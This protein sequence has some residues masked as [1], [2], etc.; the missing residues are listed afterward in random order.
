MCAFICGG[1]LSRSAIVAT[2]LVCFS[3]LGHLASAQGIAPTGIAGRQLDSTATVVASVPAPP[4]RAATVPPRPPVPAA[5]PA[6]AD[7]TGHSFAGEDFRTP[8]LLPGG[9]QLL[10]HYGSIAT[11]LHVEPS[12][13][14]VR[15]K[16]KP[17]PSGDSF[18]IVDV[19]LDKTCGGKV[20][21]V[22]VLDNQTVTEFGEIVRDV[23][24]PA[25]TYSVVVRVLTCSRGKE[26]RAQLEIHRIAFE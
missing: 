14:R 3:S 22:H 26:E 16:F 11:F 10:A 15:M 4:P 20:Q 8:A 25:G 13:K 18:P 7:V 21:R 24:V 1:P 9:A 19:Y 12:A 17:R 23:A 5:G 6:V 2:G